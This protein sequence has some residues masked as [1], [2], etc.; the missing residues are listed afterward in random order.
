MLG[1]TSNVTLREQCHP[2][3]EGQG[4]TLFLGGYIG[5]VASIQGIDYYLP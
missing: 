5:C 1:I 4:M 3:A 2:K